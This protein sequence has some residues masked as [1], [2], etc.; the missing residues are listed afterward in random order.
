MNKLVLTT[1]ALSLALFNGAAHAATSAN[2][3]LNSFSYTLIDLD[4]LDGIAPTVTFSP[5][6]GTTQAILGATVLHVANTQAGIYLHNEYRGD[7]ALTDT[8]HSLSSPQVGI[9]SSTQ[10]AGSGARGLQGASA[11]LRTNTTAMP[12]P[13]QDYSFNS[14][15]GEIKPIQGEIYLSAHTQLILTADL[16]ASTS[17]SSNTGEH[18]FASAS[19]SFS[20]AGPYPYN[21]QTFKMPHASMFL[22]SSTNDN[23]SKSATLDKT[24]SI[25]FSNTSTSIADLNVS[26][27]LSAGGS[28]YGRELTNPTP[29][30]PEP[31]TYA[32]L[33]AGLGLAGW[34]ARRKTAKSA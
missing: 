29:A 32:M 34:V 3:T 18:A 17:A 24:I 22:D 2:I 27:N 28:Q 6:P 11:S 4:P 9:V 30:V 15:G 16:S 21:S 33:L 31:D 12:P 10:T 7:D 23:D 5:W 19:F 1:C 14:T 25:S 13:S 8:S 26:S 20:M